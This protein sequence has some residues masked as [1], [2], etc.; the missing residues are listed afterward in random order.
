MWQ[1]ATIVL[2]GLVAG[3]AFLHAVGRDEGDPKITRMKQQLIKGVAELGR[4]EFVVVASARAT[5]K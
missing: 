1:A 2:L 5:V 3:V 4:L